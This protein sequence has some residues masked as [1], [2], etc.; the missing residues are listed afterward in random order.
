MSAFCMK[1]GKGL[2]EGLRAR[3]HS[4]PASWCIT[5][6]PAEHYGWDRYS[7]S[8]NTNFQGGRVKKAPTLDDVE[9]KS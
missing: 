9:A 2:T 1:C 5:C 8:S 7:V 6:P 4:G 3:G